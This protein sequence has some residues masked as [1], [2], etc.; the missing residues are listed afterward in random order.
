M[1]LEN[2]FMIQARPRHQNEV[3]QTGLEEE[4]NQSSDKPNSH[5]L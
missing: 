1:Y 3:M 2:R 5:Q 4:E